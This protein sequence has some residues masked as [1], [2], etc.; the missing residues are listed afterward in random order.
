M[1]LIVSVV[2]GRELTIASTFISN[3]CSASSF[4]LL[5]C[6]FRSSYR[7]LLA[8]PICCSHTPPMGLAVGGFLIL[9]SNW[10][11]VFVDTAIFDYDPSLGMLF[12]AP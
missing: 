12:E 10:L 9:L 11:C 2:I 8:V 4:K 3:V 6:V 7:M 5:L 1:L